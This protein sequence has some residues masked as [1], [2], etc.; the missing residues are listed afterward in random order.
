M[1]YS[2][3]SLTLIIVLLLVAGVGKSFT[4]AFNVF[5]DKTEKHE[6]IINCDL[7]VNIFL[8]DRKVTVYE[9]QVSVSASVRKFR[10]SYKIL[11]NYNY[12]IIIN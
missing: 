6:L 8:C 11:L 5:Y 4:F 10:D 2:C 9:Q 7:K 12:E 3:A 1:Q